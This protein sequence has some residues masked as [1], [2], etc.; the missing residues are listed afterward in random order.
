MKNILSQFYSNGNPNNQQK[1]IKSQ[2]Y[3]S[4]NLG[5]MH[6]NLALNG[7]NMLENGR[8]KLD[9]MNPLNH[10]YSK[11]TLQDKNEFYNGGSLTPRNLGKIV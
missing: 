1:D 6:S 11:Q 3:S 2:T 9:N 8:I 10:S 7:I 5:M 4:K